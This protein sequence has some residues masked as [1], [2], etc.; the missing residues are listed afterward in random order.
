VRPRP[1]APVSTP[2]TW[3]Q[4]SK[5]LDPARWNIR[6]APRQMKKSGDP[7]AGLLTET[8]DVAALLD[9]LGRRLG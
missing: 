2:L 1:G 5:R 9:G 3:G 6:T 8:A 4:V 7:L